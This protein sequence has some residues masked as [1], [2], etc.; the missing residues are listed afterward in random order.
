MWAH[1]EHPQK[2]ATCQISECL[3]VTKQPPLEAD[4]LSYCTQE[5]KKIER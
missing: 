4:E 3:I 2:E 1:R 5:A